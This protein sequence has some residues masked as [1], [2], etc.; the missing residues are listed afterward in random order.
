[1]K[2]DVEAKERVTDRTGNT[3]VKDRSEILN[4]NIK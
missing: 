2:T 4:K 1:M 3:K